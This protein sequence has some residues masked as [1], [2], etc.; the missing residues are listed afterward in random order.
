MDQKHRPQIG[1][2]LPNSKLVDAPNN[3]P[4]AHAE[5]LGQLFDESPSRALCP[6]GGNLGLIGAAVEFRL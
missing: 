6:F 3:H 2:Y 5:L 1:N 4:L